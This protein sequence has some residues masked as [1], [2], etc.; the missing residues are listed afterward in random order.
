MKERAEME[1]EIERTKGEE[2][3]DR[4][5]IDGLMMIGAHEWAEG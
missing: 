1:G 2:K 4:G 5:L 3:T